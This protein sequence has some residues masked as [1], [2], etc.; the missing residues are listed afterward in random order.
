[1]ADMTLDTKGLACPLPVLK[2]KKALADVA[3]GGTLEVLA[4]DPASVEDFKALAKSTGTQ[5]IEQTT[6]EGGVFRHVLR[7]PA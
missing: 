1:M 5:L 4:T 2:A 6:P 7:K 3:K